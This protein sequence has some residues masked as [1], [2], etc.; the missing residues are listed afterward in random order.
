MSHMINISKTTIA[1]LFPGKRIFDLMVTISL[2]PLL[3]PVV[4]LVA[5]ATWTIHGRPLLLRID[6]PGFTVSLLS[7][8]NSER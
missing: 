8:I 7:C 6:A 2:F 4:G 1:R 5:L 3:L